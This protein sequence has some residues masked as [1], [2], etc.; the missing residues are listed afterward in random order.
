M[1]DG[2]SDVSLLKFVPKER[3]YLD[4]VINKYEFVNLNFLNNIDGNDELL[5]IF[6]E[7]GVIQPNFED[8]EVMPV[9]RST[10]GSYLNTSHLEKYIAWK[11]SETVKPN[12][13]W[14]YNKFQLHR[15]LLQQIEFIR[16]ETKFKN[17]IME[18][19]FT[20]N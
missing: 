6:E 10:Y 15:F 19:L 14:Q 12:Q 17:F 9:F 18:S 5:V 3:N 1:A 4:G 13:T 11:Y 2:S 7:I 16:E 8:L 20:S